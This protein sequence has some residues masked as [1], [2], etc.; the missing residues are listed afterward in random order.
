MI[1]EHL[2]PHLERLGAKVTPV[3]NGVEV[4]VPGAYRKFL[5]GPN[6]MVSGWDSAAGSSEGWRNLRPLDQEDFDGSAGPAGDWATNQHLE[7]T[8]ERMAWGSDD[9]SGPRHNLRI[10][11]HVRQHPDGTYRLHHR[12][13]FEAGPAN[14]LELDANKDVAPNSHF[15]HG[16]SAVLQGQMPIE[17]L[18]DELA[19]HHGVYHHIVP[20]NSQYVRTYS[21]AI[22]SAG[23]K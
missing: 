7:G 22:T 1:P 20:E 8:L 4:H 10:Y 11:Q 16:I 23:S 18:V 13:Q 6:G 14:N 12:Y 3:G 21:S 15:G 19:E 5:F 2:R 17:A 9:H